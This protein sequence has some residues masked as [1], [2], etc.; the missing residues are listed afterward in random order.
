MQ[1]SA[2]MLN[3]LNQ[4]QL[5]AVTYTSGSLLVLAGAGSGKTRVLTTRMAWLIRNAY[6]GIHEV[7]AVTFT[8]KAAREMLN[9]VEHLLEVDTRYM[10]V[11]TFHALALRLLRMH[12][13]EAQLPATFQIIDANDQR[14]LIK[15]LLK[16]KN[17]DEEYYPAKELQNYIN[18]QKEQGQR[19]AMLSRDVLANQRWLELY[20]LYEETCNREGLV[21]F[22]ELL[23][24]SYE[25][26]SIHEELLQRYQQQFKH[27]LVDEFQDTNQLQYKWLGLLV[28]AQNSIFAVGDDD[29]S[30]YSFRGAQVGNMRLFLRD[31]NAPEPLRLE[32]NY[33]STPLI[34]AAANAIINHND[35]RIGKNLWTLNTQAEKIRLYEGYTEEDEAYFVLD[36]IKELSATG[37]DL[38]SIAILYRSNAQS[39]VFEYH[40]YNSGIAYK[41]YGGLR[42]F[43]RQEIKRIL[44]YL[45]LVLNLHDNEALLRIIN[46]PPRGIGAK[47]VEQLQELAAERGV[48][49]FAALELMPGKTK[50]AVSRFI[51]L[52][53]ELQAAS[54]QLDLAGIIDY[55]MQASGVIEYYKGEKDGEERLENLSELLSAV[56]A[57]ST[58]H[59]ERSLGEFLAH[60]ILESAEH[61]SGVGAAAVQL[62]TVHAA[63][64]LEFPVVFVVGLEDGL[65]PHENATRNAKDIEEERRLMY[66]AVTR[67]AQR[68]YLLRACSRMLWGKRQSAPL[69]RF[70]NEIPSE[71]LINI[72]GVTK[73]G[74]TGEHKG[75]ALEVETKQNNDGVRVGDMIR[76]AKFGVGK[77]VRLN[78]DG[79]RLTAEILFIGMGKKTLDLNVAQIAKV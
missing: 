48:S 9:R 64:G 63:K 49:L 56:E 37:V 25:L 20:A 38:S 73:V 3:G 31:F 74:Y 23:L 47:T 5:Q 18:Y 34:L 1:N 32:Q 27:I 24:R 59:P 30:I 52:L 65:F 67:A 71:L 66:V 61:Q 72:S 6:L 19:C 21:D 58:T 7:L 22:T 16:A 62:M 8:N 46:F 57:F 54:H 26:L 79:K 17:L 39:R 13:A 4:E 77:I 40:L 33:R 2:A 14:S 42:F 75:I 60:T 41:V 51:A 68:L 43:D 69:S 29:Q 12:Y 78:A 55:I 44:A 15:R 36:E 53:L 28:H 35:G 45:R 11:G 76:H 70:V 10:W 50:P